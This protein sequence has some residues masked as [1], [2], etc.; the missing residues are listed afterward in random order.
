MGG[1]LS[2]CEIIEGDFVVV[3]GA[4]RQN[5]GKMSMTRMIAQVVGHGHYDVF[6]KCMRT[7]KVFKRP[8]QNC[9]K[10]PATIP[11][12]PSTKKPV[13]GDLVLS[14]S[15]DLFRKE[16]RVVGIL[17]ELIDE[18]PRDLE[19]RILSGSDTHVVSFDTLITLE[20]GDK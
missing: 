11:S 18:P 2:R 6:L 12:L 1:I 5:D 7:N 8:I 16:K 20:R 17:I 9:Y 14:L 3:V 19:G 13:L 10:I 15:S 4:A